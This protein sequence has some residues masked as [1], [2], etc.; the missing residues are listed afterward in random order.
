MIMIETIL[1]GR[2]LWSYDYELAAKSRRVK[3]LS[4]LFSFIKPLSNHEGQIILTRSGLLITGDEDLNIPLRSVNEIYLGFDT[5]FPAT[6]VKNFGAFWQPLR[7]EF[8]TSD[9]TRKI[10]L[11]IDYNGLTA[12]NQLWYD[13]IKELSSL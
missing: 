4:G 10:Y 8:L 6:S 2:V 12:N 9:E 3:F 1:K 5:L 11:A 7:L 13:T